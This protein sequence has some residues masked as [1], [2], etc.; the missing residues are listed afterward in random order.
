MQLI[1][2]KCPACGAVANIQ[3][4]ETIFTCEY[5]QNRIAV[6]KPISINSVVDGLNEIEQTK[7]SNYISILNQALSAGNYKEAYDYCNKALEINPKAATLWEN[8]A[9]CTFWLSTMGNLEEKTGEIISYLNAS[10]QN[11]SNSS[12]YEDT[13]KN[14]A[15]NLF[16]ITK[17]KYNSVSMVRNANNAFSYD[18]NDENEFISCFRLFDLCYQIYPKLWYLEKSLKLLTTGSMWIA[19]N[20][21]SFISN[22]HK[23][24]A[25]RKAQILKDKI[26]QIRYKDPEYR[27]ADEKRERE[28]K[29]SNENN[30]ILSKWIIIF[31]LALG[32]IGII[33][34]KLYGE[35]ENIKSKDLE[36]YI[37]ISAILGIGIGATI[38]AI[39]GNIKIK[40]FRKN[41]DN[42]IINN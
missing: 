28:M 35:I 22:R 13:T 7:Y 19:G 40:S 27:K 39:I 31:G 33:I 24:D 21:N 30:K 26:K 18:F 10:K 8:K 1:T 42:K 14:I 25:V 16:E 3:G 9:I 32:I 36:A 15:D 2:L 38:G 12:S 4:N 11:D 17:Y 20:S 37:V 29:I 41:Q 6:M 34:T 5:C 23:F